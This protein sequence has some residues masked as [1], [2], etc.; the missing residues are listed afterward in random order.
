MTTPGE[1]SPLAP[2]SPLTKLPQPTARKDKTPEEAQEVAE[3]Q[4]K[5]AALAQVLDRGLVNARLKVKDGAR[6]RYYA[7]VRDNPQDLDRVKALGF[8]LEETA[9]EGLHGTGD[10]RRKIGDVVLVSTSMEN[11]E[12]I[13]EVKAERR[14]KRHE[15]G[16][17][18]K[19][20]LRRS[21]LRNPDVA[22]LNPR[23]IG[24]EVND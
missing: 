19:E 14:R 23:G 13:E 11:Y 10:N 24:G 2:G 21:R 3:R 12:I 15:A 6:D 16:D 9:G 20:Y 17:P 22:V 4:R 7:Y 18:K 8:V 5:K 1:R